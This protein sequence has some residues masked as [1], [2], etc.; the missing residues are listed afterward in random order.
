VET[1]VE[2][3]DLVAVVDR[4]LV[5]TSVETAANQTSMAVHS[6]V[7]TDPLEHHPLRPRLGASG[8]NALRHDVLHALL[9]EDSVHFAQEVAT[10]VEAKPLSH[11]QWMR[12]RSS[13]R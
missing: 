6:L 3:A 1:L 10:D 12:A 13:R 7:P 11:A 5:D 8:G 9:L 2:T 4:K